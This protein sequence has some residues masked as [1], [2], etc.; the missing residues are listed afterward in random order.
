MKFT[1]IDLPA[2][3]KELGVSEA[4]LKAQYLSGDHIAYIY[5][6]DEHAIGTQENYLPACE[7]DAF[8]FVDWR[9]FGSPLSAE[10][11]RGR[12]LDS[13]PNPK[14]I[15]GGWVGLPRSIAD[16][17][18]V[19]KEEFNLHNNHV[20]VVDSSLEGICSVRILAETGWV[21]EQDGGYRDERLM[22][23]ASDIYFLSGTEKAMDVGFEQRT[24]G[25]LRRD[26]RDTYAKIIGALWLKAHDGGGPGK[27]SDDPYTA[28]KS[29][30]AMLSKHG[31]APPSADKIGRVLAKEV[32]AI[33][34]KIGSSDREK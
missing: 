18:L 16:R 31:V 17:L 7:E 21:P 5:I 29:L 32:A 13:L 23:T 10:R 12:A 34:I 8:P 28:G 24:N 33:G 20:W 1:F 22:I 25:D 15:I 9:D 4:I 26:A 3:A 30:E 11:G 14:Y 27:I 6:A 19:K 2:K